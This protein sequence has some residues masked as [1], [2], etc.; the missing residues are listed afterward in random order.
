MR[1]RHSL[2]SRPLP[3]IATAFLALVLLPRTAHA[4][5]DPTS[6]SIVLQVAL[7][8]ILGAIVTIKQW[9]GKARE[10]FRSLFRRQKGT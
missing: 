3:P 2:A 1:R 8:G 10:T 9:W 7:A 6:G 4:Y 5:V